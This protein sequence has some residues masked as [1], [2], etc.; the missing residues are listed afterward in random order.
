MRCSVS[1]K[2]QAAADLKEIGQ[3][4]WA[5]AALL[6]KISISSPSCALVTHD[7]AVPDR[8]RSLPGMAPSSRATPANRPLLDVEDADTTELLANAKATTATPVLSAEE[9]ASRQRML[10]ICFCLMLVGCL[11][12]NARLFVDSAP[13]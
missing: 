10:L 11:P 3:C 6:L 8:T 13:L 7:Q 4:Q 12:F 2:F 9:E 1:V 5:M